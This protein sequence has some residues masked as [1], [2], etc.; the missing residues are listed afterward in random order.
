MKMDAVTLEEGLELFKLPR[1]LG[2]TDDG[3]SISASIGRFGPYI[4]YGSKFVSLKKDDDPYTVNLE[5]ALELIEEKKAA[6]LAKI[7]QDFGDGLQILKGRWGPFVTDGKTKTR[8]PKERDPETVSH[9]EALE[10]IANAP[11]PK[12]KAAAGKKAAASA[13]ADKGKTKEKTEKAAS[14]GKTTR[15]KAGTTTTKKTGTARKS[16]AKKTTAAKKSTAGSTGPGR[17]KTAGTRSAK[18]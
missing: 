14:K 18:S 9:E 3:E 1:K 4:R 13:D 6:D 2:S 10:M 15:K 12:G 11:P 16:T 17:K 7:I 5:R 8:L